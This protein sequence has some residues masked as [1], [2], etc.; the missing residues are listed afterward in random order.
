MMRLAPLDRDKLRDLIEDIAAG[1]KELKT[2]TACPREEFIIDRH[3]YAETEHYFRR[4]LEGI[5]TAATHILSRLP[6]ETKDYAAVI[7]SLGDVGIVNPQF[8]QRNL[9][10]AGYRNRLVHMYW[11]VSTGELYDTVRE[12]LDDLNEFAEA[13]AKVIRDPQKFGIA[14]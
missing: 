14:E 3:R 5:L 9:G 2:L 7:K 8:A 1:R 10:L 13:F 6:K 12:H 11:E 4:V